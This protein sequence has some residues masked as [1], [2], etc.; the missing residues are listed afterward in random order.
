MLI[1]IA[2]LVMINI[3]AIA[4]VVAGQIEYES[5]C[6]SN[7]IRDMAFMPDDHGPTNNEERICDGWPI[8]TDVIDGYD[9]EG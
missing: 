8:R 5:I 4:V 3:V 2:L 1:L 9:D 7:S 6:P